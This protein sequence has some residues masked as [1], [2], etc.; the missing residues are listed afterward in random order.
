VH[1]PAAYISEH[2]AEVA[3]TSQ[4]S[5]PVTEPSSPEHEPATTGAESQT[6]FATLWEFALAINRDDASALALAANGSDGGIQI[7]AAEL[8]KLLSTVWFRSVFPRLSSSWRERL[9]EMLIESMPVQ[10]QIVRL[11]RQ[12]VPLSK[13]SYAQLNELMERTDLPD[14]V[15][16]DVQILV[17][18][19][20][21]WGEEALQRY[22]F[23]GELPAS[24]SRFG[25][26]LQGLRG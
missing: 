1:A 14:A 15:R 6:G 3:L 7:D 11:G 9:F 16:P 24:P 20:R 4:V 10:D 2:P 21:L 25:T 17:A 22:Q 13:A 18:V 8:R 26:L 12:L 23:T 19:G 5:T